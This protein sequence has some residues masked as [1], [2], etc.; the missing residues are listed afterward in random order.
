MT[1]AGC[2]AAE[3]V[4]VLVGVL[5]A[6]G[7]VAVDFWDVEDDGEG[8][9]CGGASAPHPTSAM[10]AA[11]T[12][13]AVAGRRPMLRRIRMSDTTM[14]GAD[15]TAVTAAAGPGQPDRRRR[16]RPSVLSGGYH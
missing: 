5:V 1:A 15:G 8:G 3:V 16:A 10:A 2:G 12:A 11:A 9:A 13:S 7:R 6:L 4:L 14:T